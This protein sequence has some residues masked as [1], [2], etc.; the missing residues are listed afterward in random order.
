LWRGVLAALISF[1]LV[2]SFFHGWSFDGDG[3]ALS[4]AAVP[5]SCD[6]SGKA[7]PDSAA[8]HG[9]H[10]LAHVATVAPQGIAETIEYVTRI[11]RLI[12]ML[13]PDSADLASPFKPPRA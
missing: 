3:G 13:A 12:A 7:A 6:S 11:D 5:A 4:V 1:A 2:L 10:C 8:P 9:D